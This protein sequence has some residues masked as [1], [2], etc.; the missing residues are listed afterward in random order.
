[1][2][3]L[4]VLSHSSKL[5][6]KKLI[7]VRNTSRILIVLHVILEFLLKYARSTNL[8]LLFKKQFCWFEN[9]F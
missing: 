6:R 8:I 3:D 7:T 5:F 1:M 9:R 2:A 4:I